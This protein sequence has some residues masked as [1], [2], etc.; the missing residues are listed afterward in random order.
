MSETHAQAPVSATTLAEAFDGACRRWAERPAISTGAETTTYRELHAAVYALAAGYRRIGIERGDRI[1][2]QLPNGTEHVLA[3]AAAWVVG[4]V[5]IGVDRDLTVAEVAAIVQRTQAAALLIDTAARGRNP[6]EV[7]SHIRQA[8][9]ETRLIGA[10]ELG[11]AFGAYSLSTLLESNVPATPA[12]WDPPAPEDPAIIFFT[13]GTTGAPKGSV[14]YHRGLAEGWP[15]LVDELACTSEDVHLVQLPLAHGFGLMMASV[16]LFSGGC[17]VPL[18]R[19]SPAEAL[20]VI[21]RERVSV[22][23]GTPAH[24][25]LLLDR[26]NARAHDVSSLRIGVGSAASFP[27]PLLE[28]IFDVLG[29]DILLLYG[30][31]EGLCV[32]TTD[33]GDMLDG[34]VG[35]ADPDSVRIVGPDG[36]A[37]HTGEVGEIAIC[38]WMPVHYWDA[39]EA[40]RD[41][42]AW[43]HTGDMGRID[44]DG[45]LYVL[46]RV[47]HQI[48]RGGQKVDPVEVEA[49]LWQLGGATDLAVIGAPDPVLGEIVC[50]CI[51]PES[52][53]TP[54]L[55][56]VRELLGRRLARHK[57]PERLCLLSEIPRTT[58]GKVDREALREASVGSE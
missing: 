58:L 10:G 50:A 34:S 30:S 48:N 4:A 21:G 37:V 8:H 1:V 52:S 44:A 54:T 51:V 55:D 13:S 36:A 7:A 42:G 11:A 46:G 27:R 56:E 39:P 45:R 5:H 12:Q 47:R 49:A 3:M 57:L 31:S 32:F 29:M 22:L 6:A 16:A 9:A 26:L 41:P 25:S 35:R 43:Y 14:G 40:A 2:C 23:N 17:L 15:W 28:G 19:F 38:A 24:F 18:A 53:S 33:R 20:T